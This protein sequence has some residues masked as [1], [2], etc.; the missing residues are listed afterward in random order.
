ML[1][2][3][4]ILQFSW[5]SIARRMTSMLLADSRTYACE[6]TEILCGLS[7]AETPR[8]TVLIHFGNPCRGANLLSDIIG[9]SSSPN[10]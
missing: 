10:N 4:A 3:M 5:V 7:A 2:E 6:K 8:I 9:Q 1:E